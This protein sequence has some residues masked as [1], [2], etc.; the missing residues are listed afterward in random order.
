M[1]QGITRT[2]YWDLRQVKAPNALLVQ[3]PVSLQMEIK[4][5]DVPLVVWIP[6][7]HDSLAQLKLRGLWQF[8]SSYFPEVQFH[9]VRFARELGPGEIKDNGTDFLIGA[10]SNMDRA[11]HDVLLC[12]YPMHFHLLKASVYDVFDPDALRLQCATLSV[13][14]DFDSSLGR[15]MGRDSLE[16]GRNQSSNRVV[17]GIPSVQAF[18]VTNNA[19]LGHMHS[20]NPLDVCEQMGR[21][22]RK[23]QT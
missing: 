19:S 20:D 15:L 2:L 8:F 1:V 10:G 17:G 14:V 16:S 7:D 21:I 9:F 6:Y 4:I 3:N 22:L 18:E 13:G 11:V 12:R 23:R 5:A